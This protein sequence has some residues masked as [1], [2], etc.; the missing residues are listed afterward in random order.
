MITLNKHNVSAQIKD[1]YAISIY[2]FDFK[3][4]NS[5]ASELRFEIT[6]DPDAFISKFK[7]NI[8]GEL[9]IGQIK[10]K[11]TASN[12]YKQAKQKKANTILTSQPHNDIPNVFEIKTNIDSKS[13]ISLEITIEQYLQKKFNFNELTIQ[14]LR[15]F[16]K[17]NINPRYEYIKFTFNISD[18]CGMYDILIP[19]SSSSSSSM[20]VIINEQTMNAFNK[21]CKINGK[22]ASSQSDINEITLKYKIK[23]E[24]EEDCHCL[25]D[26]KS[27][28]F[29]H[30]IS[31]VLSVKDEA[32]EHNNNIVPR[33]V[34]FVIDKSGS[35]GGS[36]WTRTVSATIN[37]LKQLRNGYD[38]FN[39]ILFNEMMHMLFD[40]EMC[41]S[42]KES[43]E[44]GINYMNT[45]NAVMWR[46]D[47]Y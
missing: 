1:R 6:I 3:N 31:N 7:A 32:N 2:S 47:K 40:T 27:N 17:Y 15:N 23:G 46:R 5:Y 18:E 16:N 14:I 26:N 42:S 37:G 36:K 21:I 44:N 35:M 11:A 19:S 39:I 33:R 20:G 28:T 30:V 8:D 24:S 34:I 43:I 29:C 25:F 4:D 13:K 41:L 38:R 10:E 22:I 12:Q 9:F 45:S